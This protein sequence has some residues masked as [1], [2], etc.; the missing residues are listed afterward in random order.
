MES[1]A[2]RYARLRKSFAAKVAAVP[3]ER[4]A[5]QSPCEEWTTRDLVR[6]VV[7]TQGMFESM[8]GR[9]LEPGPSVDADPHKAFVFAT[10]QV[11]AHLDD[12]ETATVGYEGYFGPTTFED[13]V[14]GFLSLDLI[15][16]GWDLARAAGIDEHID[17]A[18]ITWL[19]SRVEALEDTMRGPRTFGQAIEAE[20]EATDQD[21]LLAFLGRQP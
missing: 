9:E 12:P 10:D 11:Q 3:E 6:H 16:H 2:Q 1:K 18:D 8:V 14:D 19:W 17:P 20:P 7:E 13:S 4:W 21:K 5:N 15:V